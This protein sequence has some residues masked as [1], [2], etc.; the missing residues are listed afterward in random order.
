MA[1][2]SDITVSHSTEN[3]CI[4]GMKGGFSVGMQQ[5]FS[6]SISMYKKYLGLSLNEFTSMMEFSR[7]A[8]QDYLNGRGNPTLSTVEHFAEKLNTDPLSLLSGNFTP[9]QLDNIRLLLETSQALMKL[10]PDKRLLFAEKFLELV[11]L[12]SSAD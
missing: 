12:L 4:I 7:S 2:K 5:N 8:T 10:A 6:N 11:L 1:W 9:S 3:P